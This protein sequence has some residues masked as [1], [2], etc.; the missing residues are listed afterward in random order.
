MGKKKNLMFGVMIFIGV[1]VVFSLFAVIG[2]DA[3]TN[4][5]EFSTID[6]DNNLIHVIIEKVIGQQFAI[7]L[8]NSNNQLTGLFNP[9]EK[10]SIEIV[11]DVACGKG[12]PDSLEI[13]IVKSGGGGSSTKFIDLTPFGVSTIGS[14]ST[15]RITTIMTAPSA[16]GDY[17]INYFMRSASGGSNLLAVENQN[18]KIV[19]QSSAECP[20]GSSN[21]WKE[22]FRS[23]DGHGSV[24]SRSVTTYSNT[25][26]PSIVQQTRT[27]CDSN[28]YI[29]GTIANSGYGVLVCEI[30]NPSP[31][32]TLPVVTPPV[33]TPLIICDA[34]FVLKDNKCVNP[35]E[36]VVDND[37][38]D[39]NA[40]T[41]DKCNTN[42]KICEY[43]I[44]PANNCIKIVNETNTTVFCKDYQ[45]VNSDNECKFSLG[46]FVSS[47]GLKSFYNDYKIQSIGFIVL[48]FS[49]I[50]FVG[51]IIIISRSGGGGF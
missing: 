8:R 20:A 14:C 3:T 41:V 37:C 22:I 26:V 9:N 38:G 36:C 7:F 1:M 2:K 4:K 21:E 33:V 11:A 49:I 24:Q 34:P 12:E 44:V 16:I 48:L 51:Y 17:I 39:N 28:Y 5:Y 19:S 50:I 15:Q 45:D 46:K 25:C 42:T 27:V 10:I 6:K 18:F 23:S 30:K 35:S 43:I 13:N 47:G 29:K 32:P 40:C 31:V